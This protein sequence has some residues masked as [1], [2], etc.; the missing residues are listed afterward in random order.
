MIDF[1]KEEQNKYF[2]YYSKDEMENFNLYQNIQEV[3]EKTFNQKQEFFKKIF[4]DWKL[5]QISFILNKLIQDIQL[6]FPENSEMQNLILQNPLLKSFYVTNSSNAFNSNS[7]SNNLLTN[8]VNNNYAVSSSSK[9]NNQDCNS[10]NNYN[11]NVNNTCFIPNQ[12]SGSGS[13]GSLENCF[14]SSNQNFFNSNIN[15]NINFNFINNCDTNNNKNIKNNHNNS[16]TSNRNNNIG[17]SFHNNGAEKKPADCNNSNSF[18]KNLLEINGIKIEKLDF[19]FFTLTSH[20]EKLIHYLAN[21]LD[22]LDIEILKMIQTELTNSTLPSEQS[23]VFMMNKYHQINN[24]PEPD[25]NLFF[26]VFYFCYILF[27]L[28]N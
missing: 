4:Q 10:I 14:S 23:I 1:L 26:L 15:T 9:G 11:N 19:S 24:I 22:A 3:D 6:Y 21:Y 8:S 5:K 18:Y 13:S 25:G 17:I 28:F 7:I 20:V 16:N 2:F 27:L 12:A